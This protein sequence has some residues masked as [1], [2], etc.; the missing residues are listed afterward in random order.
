[1]SEPFVVISG[2]P[3]YFLECQCCSKAA[4][5]FTVPGFKFQVSSCNSTQLET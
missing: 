2:T 5:R 3:E 1:L 4:G